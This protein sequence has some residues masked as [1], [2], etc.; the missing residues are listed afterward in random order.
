VL[1]SQSRRE[2]LNV[3]SKHPHDIHSIV[4]VINIQPTAVR[5]HLQSLLRLGL[6]E[7]YEEKR[8]IGRPKMYYKLTKKQ[9]YVG[10][11]PRN[12]LML[13][14]LLIDGMQNE[15]SPEETQKILRLTGYKIGGSLITDLATKN[16]ID[17]WAPKQF[18]EYY[19]NEFLQEI[20]AQPEV[21]ESNEN[22]VL[23]RTHSCLFLEIAT[24]HSELVC[25]VLDASIHQ[26]IA[27]ALGNVK[28]MR[29]QCMGHGS[30][31]CELD[32][33]WINDST[34]KV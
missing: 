31:H 32:F 14:E 7:T 29:T 33:T 10:F 22:H 19:V 16:N 30:P 20:G 9:V 34:K 12:Y 2:I 8:G 4:E 23:V 28:V 18:I 6:I 13:S 21:L 24:K 11:P 17:I 5:Y 27:D 1:S 3:L 25:D 26:G 15:L